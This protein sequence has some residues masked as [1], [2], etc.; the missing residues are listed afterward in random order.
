[1]ISQEMLKL[2]ILGTIL[3]ITD[4]RLQPHLPGANELMTHST[5]QP[6]IQQLIQ[7]IQPLIQQLIQPL[8]Q[9]FTHRTHSPWQHRVSYCNGIMIIELVII[10]SGNGL[11]PVWHQAIPWPSADLPWIRPLGTN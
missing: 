5:T 7:L 6:L 9:P 1:M 10:G 2:S 3:K 11:L 4:L 8:F